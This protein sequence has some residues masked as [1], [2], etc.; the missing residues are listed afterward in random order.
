[1]ASQIVDIFWH[2]IDPFTFMLFSASYIPSTIFRLVKRGEFRTFL[3]PSLFKDAWFANFWSDVGPQMRENATPRAGPL[4]AE[5][6]GV[7]LDIG[8]GSGE[9][10]KLFDKTKV[11]K[12]YG[13]EPNR[14][15]H[16]ALRKRVHEAGLE[17]IYEIVPVGV[18]DLGSKWVEQGEADAVVTI[19]CLCSVP[20]PRKMIGELYGYLKKGGIWVVYEHVVA[21]KH[22]GVLMKKYQGELFCPGE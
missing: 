3:S 8:P 10:L 18:E 16:A 6:H 11:T 2:I 22:Q 13:V 19:Q 15:H 12:I 7:V 1:M 21:F 20:E 4:I 17:G 14:D 9:W 5:A